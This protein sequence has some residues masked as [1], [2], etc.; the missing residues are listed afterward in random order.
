MSKNLL[1]YL[2]QEEVY[3]IPSR[4][5]LLIPEEWNE[6]GDE[7]QRLLKK[8]VGALNKD[9]NEFQIIACNTFDI[10]DFRIH[11]PE[12][13]LSFGSI[14]VFPVPYYEVAERGQVKLLLSDTLKSLDEE[15]KKK[16]WSALKKLFLS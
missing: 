7:E 10:D 15:K 6:L 13:I 5:L 16:L 12:T 11:N 2:Y 8:I 1:E 3:R 14:P 9:L 4:P